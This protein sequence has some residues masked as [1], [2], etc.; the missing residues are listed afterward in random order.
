MWPAPAVIAAPP[1]SI[2]KFTD[3]AAGSDVI[4][5]D[6]AVSIFAIDPSF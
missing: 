1:F 6:S 3:L 5:H 4:G 2:V